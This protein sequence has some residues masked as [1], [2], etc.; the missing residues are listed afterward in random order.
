M[1]R[2]ARLFL[3]A[4]LPL[5][6]TA[7][8]GGSPSGGGSNAVVSSVTVTPNTV[9]LSVGETRTLQAEVSGSAGVSQAV[10]WESSDDAIATVSASG[11]V[12]AVKAGGPVT[13]TATSKV[14][15]NKSGSASITVMATAA[16]CQEFE[17]EEIS[18][19]IGAD[20]TLTKVHPAG[21]VDYRVTG[22]LSV[23]AAL[24]IEKGV[25]IEFAEKAGL[26]VT[27]TGSLTAVGTESAPI[28]L[29]GTKQERGHWEAI[30]IRSNDPANQLAHVTL[31]HA[32][33]GS[34]YGATANAEAGLVLWNGSQTKLERNTFR[35]NGTYGLY[36]QPDAVL[37]GFTAN[38]F[39]ANGGAPLR[40]HSNQLGYL[41]AASNYSGRDLAA[42]GANYIEVSASTTTRS[43]TWPKADLPYRFSGQHFI[44]TDD[45]GG[46]VTLAAGA[47]IEF[48]NQAGL[49]V[50]KG[51][52]RAVGTED[53][54]ITLTGAVRT[55]TGYW[56]AVVFASNNPDN[57]LAHVDVAFGGAGSSYGFSGNHEANVIVWGGAQLK[58]GHTTFSDS[59]KYG[60][61]LRPDA[62]LSGF[63]NNSF[64][65]NS[66]PA[67]FLQSNQLG[68]LDA[69]TRYRG[70]GRPNN[71][72]AEYIEVAASTTSGSQTW[73]KTDA[74]Y[75]FN[76]EHR[77]NGTNT[78]V[79]I[80]PGARL[81]FGAN[82]GIRVNDG[83][84]TAIGT[85]TEKI[86]FT[87]AV[88]T[89]GFW[90]ALVFASK[91]PGNKLVHV[92]VSYGGAGLSWG[93][94]NN[95]K[96]N[97]IV[98]NNGAMLELRDSVVR[99]SE[100]LCYHVLGD[101]QLTQSGNTWDSCN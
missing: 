4:L 97:I 101:G 85:A 17:P 18:A 15:Q 52:F 91:N 93:F 27:T 25:K 75:R 22:L 54:R 83:A 79:T 73:P 41:D 98:W 59:G 90:E 36:L 58:V 30:V 2:L 88:E 74:P 56:E 89:K 35:Q 65:G 60:L 72:G 76:G 94:S 23:S 51:A 5:I 6:I 40:L 57:E 26:N 84:L 96:A 46:R 67:L 19:N 47:T 78:T 3:L 80:S 64:A 49:R 34:S 33:A 7:C 50:N 82:A 53:E 100:D 69:A 28:T 92:D 99:H 66:G 42:N 9:T 16:Q 87:G 39:S 12:T 68:Y 43:Q 81:E 55:E 62:R 13:I 77:V 86:V 20:R 61:Y 45:D 29:T 71:K 63:S 11:V 38:T 21:C 1:N 32:G 31:E 24:T 95:H 14:D 70:E 8:G 37:S 10:T 48:A 44:N